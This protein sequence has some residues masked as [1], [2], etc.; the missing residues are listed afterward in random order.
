M[1]TILALTASAYDFMVDGLCYNI[2]DFENLYVELTYEIFPENQSSNYNNLGGSLVIPERVNYSDE[3]FLVTSIGLRAFGGC[4]GVTSVTIPN[5]VTSIGSEAFWE[6]AN[7]TTAKIGD[8]VKLIQ[9]SAF[10]GCSKLANI[11]FPNSLISVQYHAFEGTLWLDRQSDGVVYAG[12][13]A[14][15]Y[16]GSMPS[17]TSIAIKEGTKGISSNIFKNCWGLLSLTIPSS[18]TYIDSNAFSGC[19]NL[20]SIWCKVASPSNLNIRS[21]VFTGVPSE[22]CLLTVPVGTSAAYR[23]INQWKTFSNINE[24][25]MLSDTIGDLNCDN[26]V[27]GADLN[28]MVN[29]MI[30]TTAYDDEEGATDLNN[31]ERLSG[32]DLNRMISIILEQ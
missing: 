5:S 2:I 9:V 6:C 21:G 18:M 14:Y 1:M 24:A 12:S 17:N 32:A 15:L 11:Q 8:S 22:S 26:V 29:Q 7:L 27:N 31:D 16:K 3:T 19:T 30:G 25:L 10:Y 20:K 28:I 23:Q 13:V 4:S